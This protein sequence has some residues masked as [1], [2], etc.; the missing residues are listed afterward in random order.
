VRLGLTANPNKPR[1]LAL[2]R[3]VIDLLGDRAELVLADE[4]AGALGGGRAGVSLDG[5]SADVLVTI[6]GDGTFLTTLQRSAVPMLAVNAGTV[7]FLAEVDGDDE[8]AFT[9]AIDRVVS[10]RYY[11]ESRMKL[12][13]EVLGA[14]LPDAT[15]ELV[16]HTSQV[17][18]MRRFEISIDGEPVGRI[19]ADGIIVATP[20]GSTSYSMAAF[21]PVIEP[22]IEGIVVT[23]LAPFRSPARALVIDP[24][25][26]IGVRLLTEG[27][28][29]VVVVDGQREVPL[30]GG[31][32]VRAYRSPR[33]AF[34]VRFGARFFHRLH[35]KRILP[36]TEEPTEGDPREDADLPTHP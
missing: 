2:A 17:A 34:F 26:S 30:A 18:K 33:P 16:V 8:A 5:L 19:H 31:G 9:A 3:R 1:A 13:S 36:W 29:G 28:D 23:A 20:T 24:L 10:G 27:K 32:E 4:T 14:P 6:G 21:G 35:G 12:A 25:R 11:V 22:T 15:N 7:G